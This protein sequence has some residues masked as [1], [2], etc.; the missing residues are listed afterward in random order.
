MDIQNLIAAVRSVFEAGVA[1]GERHLGEADIP[2]IPCP[3]ELHRVIL[4]M[5]LFSYCLG[6]GVA[7][8]APSKSTATDALR[9]IAG[10]LANGLHVGYMMLAADPPYQLPDASP[11]AAPT[12]EPAGVMA[13]SAEIRAQPFTEAQ[14]REVERM[15]KRTE[16]AIKSLCTDRSQTVPM[17]VTALGNAVARILVLAGACDPAAL[18]LHTRAFLQTVQMQVNVKLAEAMGPSGNGRP[19]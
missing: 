17:V 12:D 8:I 1:E 18:E 14:M 9:E 19:A 16:T 3:P 2:D 11:P 5:P 7:M 6:L 10:N 13:D 4:A 15:T